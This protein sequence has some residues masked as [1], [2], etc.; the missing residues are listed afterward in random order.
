MERSDD[1][2]EEPFDGTVDGRFDETFDGTFDG[3]FDGMFDGMFDAPGTQMPS[4]AA[5]A[6][7]GNISSPT[8]QL[9]QPKLK[10]T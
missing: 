4:S 2:F 5:R 7:L 3:I 8:K 6:A 9:C 10:V 1:T